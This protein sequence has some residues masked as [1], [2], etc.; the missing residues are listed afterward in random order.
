MLLT[1]SFP[2]TAAGQSRTSTGF[3]LA[4]PGVQANRRSAEHSIG[5]RSRLSSFRM[6]CVA[7]RVT[8]TSRLPA[9]PRG[10]DTERPPRYIATV[11][12]P[13]LKAKGIS[14]ETIRTILVDNPRR[15]LTFVA[16]QPLV[17]AR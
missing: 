9:T 15:V 8:T 3:P 14:D 11:I 1:R 10:V 17:A 5:A 6:S 12:V 13:G 7:C 16:P 4:T 2:I